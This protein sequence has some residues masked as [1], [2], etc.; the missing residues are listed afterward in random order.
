MLPGPAQDRPQ[1]QDQLIDVEW[2]AQIIVG[3]GV[4]AHDFIIILDFGGQE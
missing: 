3:P 1:A 2:L 4:K